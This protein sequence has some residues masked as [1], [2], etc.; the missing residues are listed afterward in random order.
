MTLDNYLQ[1]AG[2]LATLSGVYPF[3][4]PGWFCL[5]R[6]CPIPGNGK[7]RKIA[8]GSDRCLFRFHIDVPIL[9]DHFHHG[10]RYRCRVE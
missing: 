7:T 8:H 4:H 2:A 6:R 5:L 10:F 9:P 3:G 1:E